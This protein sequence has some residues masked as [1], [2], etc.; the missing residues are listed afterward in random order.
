ME[1]KNNEKKLNILLAFLIISAIAL[2]AYIVLDSVRNISALVE[3]YKFIVLAG[4][5]DL[6]LTIFYVV[7]GLLSNLAKLACIIVGL[8]IYNQWR[9]ERIIKIIL[10][11][12]E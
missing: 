11:E 1:L 10:G 7:L 5:K 3:V 12:K 8:V 2:I 4:S 6:P 9:K